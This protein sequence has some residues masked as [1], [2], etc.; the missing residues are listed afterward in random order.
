MVGSAG[1]HPTSARDAAFIRAMPKA[2]LHVHLE[3]AIAPETLLTLARR[4]GVA[5]PADDV[6]GIREWF[7]FRDFAHFIEIYVAVT[8]CLR[9]VEDYA[10]IAHEFGAAMARQNVRYAEVTFSPSTHWA[11]LGVPQEVW[12]R[13]LTAGRR[14]AEEEFGVR[15]NWVFD[16]VR[17]PMLG[18]QDRIDRADYTTAVA[19][20][21]LADGVVG[22]G[23]GGT[24]I[25]APPE[26]FAPWFDR[27]RAAGLRSVPHAGETV[28]P[29]SIWGALRAL[30]AERLGHGVRC[31]EDPALVE[32]LRERQIPLEV[33]PS[34][35]VCL[36]GSPTLA[37]H[38]LPDLLAAGLYVTLTDEYLR[39]AATFGWGID[40]VCALALN[41]ARAAL[42]PADERAALER[43]FLAAF[44]ALRASLP[45]PSPDE[46]SARA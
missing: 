15:I 38:P 20:E 46:G 26:P 39:C 16:I 9:H 12:W 32:H 41:G 7:A 2:E 14:R 30:G 6:A 11:L 42:L 25:G 29:A 17:G 13:G 4:N 31:L 21:G 10:L 35:N 40:D 19:I 43:A 8:R 18:D 23:L 44:A 33:S 3:G 45:D 28:G 24:E 1:R 5:L 27:A 34:S 22:I 37:D 36:G